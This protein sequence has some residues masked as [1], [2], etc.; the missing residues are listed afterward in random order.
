MEKEKGH[1]MI[2]LQTE[3]R[4]L[5]EAW[6]MVM[7]SIMDQGRE[8]RKDDSSRAGLLRKALDWC[9]IVITNPEDRPLVPLSKPGCVSCCDENDAYQYYLTKLLNQYPE[10]NETYTYGQYLAPLLEITTRKYTEKGFYTQKAVMPVGDWLDA[11]KDESIA[12]LRLIDTRI[13]NIDGIDKLHYYIYF[14]AWN[15]FGAFSLEMAGFQLLKEYHCYMITAASDSEREVF[16]GPTVAMS[17]DVHL[18]E[19]EWD[20]ANAWLGR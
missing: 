10:E 6:M 3:V 13:I 2:S 11:C 14:R 19:M 1:K 17:K 7:S 20:A 16:P 9:S 4:N 15:W 12:C 5:E 8:Y 18:N